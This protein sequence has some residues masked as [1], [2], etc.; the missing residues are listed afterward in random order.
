MK[1]FLRNNGILILIIALLLTLITAVLSFTFGG[2]ANPFAN[3]AGVGTQGMFYYWLPLLSLPVGMALLALPNPLRQ[4]QDF[5]P[6]VW[7]SLVT[8]IALVWSVV[9]LSGVATFIY[10]NF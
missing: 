10:A 9:S 8:V 2:V 6:R 3:L 1:D 5:R 7:K 4:A